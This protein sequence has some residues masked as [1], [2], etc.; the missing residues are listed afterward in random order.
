M[1]E[2]TFWQALFAT[3]QSL[4]DWIK[5]LWLIIPPVSP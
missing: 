1:D 5:A 4:T 2:T 3:Y